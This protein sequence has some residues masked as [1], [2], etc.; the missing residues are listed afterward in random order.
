MLILPID[1]RMVLRVYGYRPQAVYAE[2]IQCCI[3]K[4]TVLVQEILHFGLNLKCILMDHR[5][6]RFVTR[7]QCIK[8]K[9]C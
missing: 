5:V 1:G 9:Q 7:G 4:P 6:F 3:I 8:G 2:I